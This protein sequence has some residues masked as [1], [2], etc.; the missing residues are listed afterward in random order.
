MSESLEDEH[1]EDEDVI[2]PTENEAVK[3]IIGNR[4]SKEPRDDMR[5]PTR[6]VIKRDRGLVEALTLPKISLYNMRSLW[7]KIKNLSDDISLRETDICFLT[8][9]WEIKEKKKHQRSIKEMLEMKNIHYISTPRQG[10][11]RGG[12]VAIA[13]SRDKFHVS[14]L[15]I[16]VPKPIE[17][18]FALVKPISTVGK[19]RKIIA[20]CFYCPPRSKS[21]AKLVDLISSQ[22]SRLR[23]EHKGCGIIMCGD[24]ND[25]KVDQLA[26]VDPSLKQIV[27][28]PTNKN[29]DKTLDIVMTDLKH[30]YQEPIRLKA[31]ETD[32]EN[33]GVPSDHW[34]VEV[35]PRTNSTTT[36]ANTKKEVFV[37]QPMPDSLV[38]EFGPKLL[39][40]DWNCLKDG[41][42]S[43][44]MVDVFEDAA[45][46]LVNENF[47]KKSVTVR[48]G[49][50]PYFTEE[51]KAMRRKRNRIYQQSGKSE[52]YYRIK[53][54]F[55]TKVKSEA[56]KYK[57]R[58]LCEVNDGKRG[59]GYS[60]IRKLGNGPSDWDKKKEFQIP[61][62]CEKGLTP[63]EAA[64]RLAD[65]FSAISQTVQPL[66]P[67]KFYPALKEAVQEG[68]ASLIKP[69]LS[70][71]DVY[72]KFKKV[73]KPNSSVKGD[74]PK[75]LLNEYA[76]LWA[77]PVAKIF[78]K[79]IET[80]EWPAQWK[81]EHA[82]PLH[83][84]GDPRLVKDEDDVR[85]IS[86]TKFLSKVLE[87]I[88]GDWLM[89][90]LEKYVDPGQCGGLKNTSIQ[91]YLVKLL[92]FIHCGLDRRTPHAVVLAALDLSKAYNRGDHQKVIEDLYDMH[93]PNWL[94]SLL[95]SYLSERS[96]VLKYQKTEA[97]PKYL[98][99][100]FG[101]G[102]WMGGFLFLVKFNGIC[103]RPPI[104]RPI[105]GN[106]AIQL[107]YIDDSTKAATV[108]LKKSLIPD[109]ITRPF[110][111]QYHERTKMILNPEENI[112]Q[113]EL[114]RFAK[115]VA[116]NNL[117][118]NTKKSLIMMCNPSR[119]YDFPP[120]F[121]IGPNSLEVRSSLKILGVMVQN[122]LRWDEHVAEMTRK[123]S[124][125]IWV[126]R[127]MK[128][129]GIDEKT[130]C[131][132]WKAEGRVHLETAAA[133]WAS[134]LTIQ[135]KRHL[136]RVEHRAVAAFSEKR[137]DPVISCSRLGLEPL[138][139]R[140]RKLCIKFAKSTVEKSRH[141]DMF[142]KLEKPHQS[143]GKVNREWREPI[144]HT[145]RHLKSAV[146][147]LTRLLNGETM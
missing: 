58:I 45:E 40:E 79:I 123:A 41:L 72:M 141:G 117:V 103:L 140:R 87:N 119:K 118:I 74:I 25:L 98:P 135:Q 143:R 5:I 44:Q 54:E 65:H 89:P 61:S 120:E 6:K 71:H 124:K 64:N 26:T 76:F 128:N 147:Y 16:D 48:Q 81:I 28:F 109:P 114:E 130:I 129:L 112:L 69:K 145:K 131:N 46:K 78:N 32:N 47:P 34:G 20:I 14:K 27:T 60:A 21:K 115:E 133:V 101:A 73:K 39:T 85:T 97:E 35:S 146:P 70:Q 36:V 56:Q 30:G 88:L 93:T 11:K 51:L 24:R 122:D 105:S 43:T 99:G 82:V 94:L 3:T 134:S 15:N 125:N 108:N 2:G 91:H 127:R 9:I 77:G 68:K 17:C 33:E 106:E 86:K 12:G 10:T 80:S 19:A 107:K 144:C 23:T 116:E 57:N 63:Q 126:L 18:L 31:I 52:R 67:S 1:S 100:G 90:I 50:L 22:I 138:E 59:S 113:D 121:K 7:P 111:L 75:K 42:N 102:T 49:E 136:Q 137:E 4:P 96:L 37:V 132:F 110:P 142:V 29:L 13:Y 104:P 92:D 84:T 66:D 38:T 95:V 53:A 55:E 8:E 62:Y 83:K 139:A